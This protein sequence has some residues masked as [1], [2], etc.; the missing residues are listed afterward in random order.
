[1]LQLQI[2]RKY[3]ALHVG[4]KF[5]KIHYLLNNTEWLVP[6]ENL[7]IAWVEEKDTRQ[8]YFLFRLASHSYVLTAKHQAFNGL[9]C[10]LIRIDDNNYVNID[11]YRKITRYKYG[12]TRIAGNEA[13]DVHEYIKTIIKNEGEGGDTVVIK[14]T[15]E[16]YK[17]NELGDH[18]EN[19]IV[20]EDEII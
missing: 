3:Y 11:S 17:D 15:I 6:N 18:I 7:A 4:G 8:H 13:N 10:K 20:V 14:L 12:V 5:V 9:E 19:P 1:L 16:S 2:K